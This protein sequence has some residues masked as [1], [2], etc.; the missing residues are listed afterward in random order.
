[1]FS[2]VA[3]VP[4]HVAVDALEAADVKL[5]RYHR[6]Q[7]VWHYCNKGRVGFYSNGTAILIGDFYDWMTGTFGGSKLQRLETAD[8][9]LLVARVSHRAAMRLYSI[10]PRSDIVDS[11]FGTCY[12]RDDGAISVFNNG[13]AVAIGSFAHLL[14]TH[15]GVNPHKPPRGIEFCWDIDP[16]SFVTTPPTLPLAA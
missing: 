10:D 1:M 15:F 11:P 14:L 3:R 4:F 16:Q 5:T 6:R 8:T 9:T 13:G 2:R 7:Y 12:T